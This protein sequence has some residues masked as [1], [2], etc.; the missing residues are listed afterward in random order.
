MFEH[1][2]KRIIRELVKEIKNLDDKRIELVGHNYISMRE[3][4]QMVHHGLN[5]EYMAA[6]YTVDSFS[7]DSMIVGEYSAQKGYFEYSGAAQD[8]VFDKI[9]NDIE[10]ALRH[11]KPEGP[12]KIYLISNQLENPSFRAKFNKTSLAMEYG[13]RLII[14][15]ARELAKGI[16]DQT[17]NNTVASQFYRGYFPT[18]FQL[19]DNFE[20]FG[21]LP[22]ICSD[23]VCEQAI[24]EAID[25]H[26]RSGKN[27]CILSGVSGTGKTQ[28]AIDYVRRNI[29]IYPNYIW[30]SGDDWKLHTSL[31]S[32]QRSRGGAPINVAGLFNSSKSILVIDNINRNIESSEFSELAPGFER[33]GIILMTSQLS[34]P[35]NS[36]YLTIPRLS[37]NTAFTILGEVESSSSELCREFI[38]KCSFSPLILSVTKKLIAD[39]SSD[40]DDI[41]REVLAVPEVVGDSNGKS[42]LRKIL[43]GLD[44]HIMD[45][46]R[47]IARSGLNAYD[48]EFLRYFVGFFNCNSLQKLSMLIPDN[49]TGVLRI[50]DLITTA[51]RD[52]E[53]DG[54]EL[55]RSLELFVKKYSGDMTPSVIR[56]LHLSA[57]LINGENLRRGAREVDWLLYALMQ[58][59]G[60]NRLLAHELLHGHKLDK[61]SSLVLVKSVIDAKEIHSYTIED[62]E[63]R[64]KYY[65]TCIHLY[66]QLMAQD[67]AKDIYF[68]LLH[69]RGKALRRC[70]RLNEALESFSELL[71]AKPDWHATHGQIAHLGSQRG[72]TDALKLAGTESMRTLVEFIVNDSHVMPLRVILSSVARLR[73]YRNVGEEINQDSQIVESLA[74][75]IAMSALEGL[76]QFYEAFVAFTSLFGFRHSSI[77]VKLAE[78][79]PEM[80][81][82]PVDQIEKRQWLSACESLTNS[83]IAAIREDKIELSR[84]LIN[85]AL[86]FANEIID[87]SK[88]NSFEARCIAKTFNVAEK[89]DLA[90]AAIDRIDEEDVNHWLL[91][92]KSKAFLQMSHDYT[93]RALQVA[94][95]CFSSAETDEKGSQRLSIYHDLLAMCYLKLGED[96]IAAVEFEKAVSLCNNDKYQADLKNKLDGLKA[97]RHL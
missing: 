88:L 43:D 59:E 96:K 13:E 58:L 49:T 65:L 37:E 21:K 84:Q 60:Q 46:L 17:V 92:E 63:E 50:H 80:T 48:I 97:K 86:G 24:F 82:V 89:P 32:V 85:S 27:I 34:E 35:N 36:L 72:A 9:N 42:V 66:D 4:Q 5:I 33:G 2:R 31:S 25:N 79:I 47:K 93:S 64:K 57:E 45:A 91:Y 10:H 94:K 53:T 71:S 18:Y 7:D 90:L 70:G 56:Q 15:D 22:S 73:S 62:R 81:S 61:D 55:T 40:R 14:I 76:D 87:K 12:Q 16:H 29:T 41:Y 30:I 51:V 69:H 8:P 75:A 54:I 68:E 78:T 1:I 67:L 39:Q 95:E 77:C 44:R 52:E 19:L 26:Y 38:A 11:K 74:N 6:G 28:S 83:A 23:F 20:Y 3:N